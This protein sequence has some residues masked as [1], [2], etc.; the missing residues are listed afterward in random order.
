MPIHHS[1]NVARFH[2][3]ATFTRSIPSEDVEKPLTVDTLYLLY[4]RMVQ[5][6]KEMLHHHKDLD[7]SILFCEV[8]NLTRNKRVQRRMF[9]NKE[10]FE[11]GYIEIMM[12]D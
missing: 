2:L 3:D 8:S 11:V 9:F 10:I 7:T 12:L 6:A 5:T 1:G 4:F